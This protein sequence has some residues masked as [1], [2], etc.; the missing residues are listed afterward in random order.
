MVPLRSAALLNVDVVRDLIEH[1]VSGVVLPAVH[2]GVG[3]FEDFPPEFSNGS[4]GDSGLPDAGGTEQE[5]VLG[6]KTVLDRFE[7]VRH[8]VHVSVPVDDR[9]GKGSSS[10]TAPSRITFQSVTM[11]GYNPIPECSEWFRMVVSR[12]NAYAVI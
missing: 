4:A 10:K 5:T 6:A 1:R 7:G 2:V 8:L 3:D 9:G 12:Q 11:W